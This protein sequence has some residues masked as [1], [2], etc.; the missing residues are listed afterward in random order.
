MFD[1]FFLNPRPVKNKVDPLLEIV[2]CKGSHE[3]HFQ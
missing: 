2:G 3:W 1:D